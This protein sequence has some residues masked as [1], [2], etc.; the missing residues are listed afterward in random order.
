MLIG[1]AEAFWRD[2]QAGVPPPLDATPSTREY[3]RRKYPSNVDRVIVDADEALCE[4]A[5]ARMNAA[6]SERRAKLAKDG[7]DARLLAACGDHD[8]V[9]GPGWKMTWRVDKTGVRR[10]RFTGR[11]EE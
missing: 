5:D 11:G 7:N 4:V 1:G 8:G 10:Q 6:A 9:K 3:L 2:V